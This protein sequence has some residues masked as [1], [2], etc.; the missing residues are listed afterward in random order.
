MVLNKYKKA[1]F[2]LIFISCFYACVQ[3]SSKVKPD[4]SEIDLKLNF[5]NF[6]EDLFSTDLLNPERAEQDLLEKYPDFYPFYT[7]ELMEWGPNSTGLQN[8]SQVSKFINHPDI[9]DLYKTVNE[10][11]SDFETLQNEL[12]TS[13]KYFKHY[14]PE[15]TVPDIIYCISTFRQMAFTLDPDILA[16]GLDMHLGEDIPMYSAAG[17]ANYIKKNFTPQHASTHAIKVW[18]QRMIKG[19]P[20]VSKLIDQLVYRGKLMYLTDLLLP[21]VPDHIKVEYTEDQYDWCQN[22]AKEVWAF[23]IDKKLLFESESKKY[24]YYIQDGPNS[25]GMPPSSPGNIGNWLGWQIVK[26]YMEKNPE[27]SLM[28]LL[29]N[30]SGQDILKKSRYKP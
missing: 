21:D 29:N 12:V 1:F 15:A 25:V 10:R 24:L 26:S 17:F 16:I 28:D 13:F 3:K 20:P 19:P 14:F 30:N 23:F 6:S 7:N 8:E 9:I 27:T 4:I 22:N 5:H 2:L 18:V 11:F